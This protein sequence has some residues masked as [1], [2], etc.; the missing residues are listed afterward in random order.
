MAEEAKEESVEESQE[1]KRNFD[2]YPDRGGGSMGK[3]D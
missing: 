1:T 3:G 2:V